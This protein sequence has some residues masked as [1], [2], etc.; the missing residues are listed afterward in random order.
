MTSRRYLIA[1]KA[2]DQI[3]KRSTRESLI[4]RPGTRPRSC[5]C[6]GGEVIVFNLS[7]RR[8]T[9]RNDEERL[10]TIRPFMV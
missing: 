5:P 2:F 8:V 1:V 7:K 3:T 9:T 4:A 6:R 10:E